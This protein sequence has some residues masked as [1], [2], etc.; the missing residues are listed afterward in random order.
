MS[1]RRIA[2][3]LSGGGARGAYEVGVVQGMCEALRSRAIEPRIDIFTG[4]SVGAI[5]TVFLA[6]H[7][8]L[9]A[10]ADELYEVW[11]RL[12]W[13][14]HLRV[15]ALDT[16][17]WLRGA[18]R[19]DPSATEMGPS[20]FDVS[21]IQRLIWEEVR[22]ADLHDRVDRGDLRAVIVAALHVGSGRTCLFGEF[23]PGWS[24]PPSKD[25]HRYVQAVRLGERHVLASA[26]IPALFPAQ[27][28]D[29]DYYC[30]GGLRFN[31]PLAPALRSGAQGLVVVNVAGDVEGGPVKAEHNVSA[32]PSPG[33]LASR[34]LNALM[35]DRV[36]QDLEALTRINELWAGLRE[37]LDDEH[38]VKL[39]Q[40]TIERRG[41]G[42]AEVDVVA[43]SP[44]EDP[45]KIAAQQASR[46]GIRDQLG[47]LERAFVDGLVGDHPASGDL[48]AY[49]LF[50]G[51]FARELMD[52]GR[53]DALG[54]RD[55]FEALFRP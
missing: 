6:A 19:L 35:L 26:A 37:S 43:L 24:Y 36:P 48:A 52:L 53:R 3:V 23:S 25:P 9:G 34:V 17:K 32:Y 47:R 8:D 21:E 40:Q 14:D 5:N 27:K 51:S 39:Q 29:G 46:S 50:D 16:W 22:W 55:D 54:R 15:R 41:A 30:D 49:L 2:L 13:A 1:E 45:G 7:E 44:S 31:T 38:F 18:V 33:F 12:R 20:I 28:V 10:G 11:S 4:T 42:Y